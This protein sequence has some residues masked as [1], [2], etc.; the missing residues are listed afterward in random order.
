MNAII[1]SVY[2][3]DVDVEIYEPD[4]PRDDGQWIRLLIGPKEGEGE[5][6]FDVLVCTPAWLA[7]QIEGDQPT[8]IR[9]T[10]LM[11]SLDLRAAILLLEREVARVSGATWND[12]LLGLVQIGFWE[13]QDYREYTQS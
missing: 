12:L 9:H 3:T 11:T 5:E 2:S 6:S 13:F 7:R 4:D 8:L 1:R 10:V